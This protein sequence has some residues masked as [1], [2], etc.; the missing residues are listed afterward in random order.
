M[1]S[2][3]LWFRGSVTHHAQRIRRETPRLSLDP[4]SSAP[5]YRHKRAQTLGADSSR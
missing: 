4:H 2:P 3:Q 1:G 5:S